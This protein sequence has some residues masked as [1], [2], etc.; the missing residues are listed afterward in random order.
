LSVL[1]LVGIRIFRPVNARL[2][3]V[4]NAVDRNSW[5]EFYFPVS[6]AI[7]FG[8]ARGDKL[9]YVIVIPLLVLTFADA[10]GALLGT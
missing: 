4:L 2:S 9:L 6:V 1:L 7:L 8:L 10:V 5:G 3:G